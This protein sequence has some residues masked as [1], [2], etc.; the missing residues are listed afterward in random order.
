MMVLFKKINN[1]KCLEFI[2]QV[3]KKNTALK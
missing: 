2:G 1:G 3:I